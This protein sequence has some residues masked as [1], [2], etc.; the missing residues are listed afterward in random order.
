[1]TDTFLKQNN[2]LDINN[3]FKINIWKMHHIVQRLSSIHY[4]VQ[5]SGLCFL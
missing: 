5:F 4:T 2:F 1:M 3:S